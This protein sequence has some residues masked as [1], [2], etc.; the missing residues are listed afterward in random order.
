MSATFLR[1]N[2]T[3]EERIK[4]QKREWYYRNRKSV[5]RQQK[6]S[7]ERK[8]SKRNWYIKNREECVAK[9][10]EWNQQNSNQRKEIVQNY[11]YRNS[12][13]TKFW[14]PYNV[15]TDSEM[16]WIE[17]FGRLQNFD[18]SH[19]KLSKRLTLE[20]APLKESNL[21]IIHHHYLH[22]SRT[23]SQL[24]YWICIDE[25]P[26][27]VL[28][29]S[30]PRV[31]VPI[32]GIE[33]M[34]LLEL[35]R[36]WIH[37]SVQN[38]SYKDRNGKSHSL[39]VA[40][41][42]MGK[43]LRRIKKDWEEKYPTLPEVDAIVSWSDDVRHKGTIYK[44][45]NFKETGKSGGNLHGTGT[46]RKDGGYYRLNKDFRHIKTRFLYKFY[47][48]KMKKIN[49]LVRKVKSNLTPDLLKPIYREK[50]KTNP[51]FGHCYVATEG[52]YHLLQS[53]EYFPHCA[54]D[55][56][57][58]VHWWLEDGTGNRIDATREQYDLVKKVPPYAKGK[59]K[60][61][62]TKQPSK[63]TQELLNRIQ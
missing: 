14:K 4:Q 55:E 36:L 46:K 5:L 27:G 42:A 32:D 6:K 7:E 16:E 12:A 11:T 13:R 25:I 53:S 57:G 49:S 18:R 30:L 20:I 58:I 37:P 61:F 17:N 60:W 39:S 15:P 52:L 19:G 63:R 28:L 26:V 3:P 51:M 33:P 38:L 23:M 31:S 8:E 44:S 45:S 2:Q 10:L 47:G 34:K 59:K 48:S 43:S 22:R 21:V 1:Q 54:R 40:S 29:Y 24:S 50:N 56:D 9:S 62:L 35:A 41:C